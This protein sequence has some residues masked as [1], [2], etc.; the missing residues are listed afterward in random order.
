[1]GWSIEITGGADGPLTIDKNANFDIDLRVVENDSGGVDHM[2]GYVEI[3]ADAVKDTAGA[4]ADE[5]VTRANQILKG[6]VPVTVSI[7]LDG[8]EKFRF[9]PAGSIGSPRVIRFRTIDDDGAGDSH[10]R[11]HMTIY[12]KQPKNGSLLEIQSSITDVKENGKQVK[13]VWAVSAKSYTLSGAL[14]LVKG[15]TPSDK[16]VHEEIER[17]PKENRVVARWTWD[18]QAS[19]SFIEIIEEPIQLIG[20]G[21]KYIV[22]KL[23]QQRGGTAP[24]PVVHKARQ[25]PM[26]IIIRGVIR[27]YDPASL[28]P[29][30][31]HFSESKTLIKNTNEE[32]DYK[33]SLESIETGIWRLPY[34]ERWLSLDGSS[35][36]PNHSDH[37]EWVVIDPPPDGGLSK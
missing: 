25:E 8:T 9:E 11:H 28:S 12:I 32:I 36:E 20:G 26:Q 34:E 1:M 5:V 31:R 16:T 17:F 6:S 24:N 10:W 18:A 3:E 27:G 15:F 4:V 7:K 21:N 19:K 33:P 29:P 2:E 22:E 37:K 35:G 13:K 23:A 14:G 30:T